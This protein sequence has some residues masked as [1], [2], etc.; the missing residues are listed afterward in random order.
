MKVAST[1]FHKE[2]Q[3]HAI[4]RYNT[5]ARSRNSLTWIP[6]QLTDVCSTMRSSTTFFIFLGLVA[7]VVLFLWFSNMN[8]T[9]DPAMKA[10]ETF[11]NGIKK[12][13][14]AAVQS[15]LDP[16]KTKLIPA[17]SRIVSL[18]FDAVSGSGAFTKRDAR[19]MPFSDFANIDIDRSKGI[20]KDDNG[21]AT[22]SCGQYSL[23]LH[24]VGN[25]WKVFYLD[26]LE[27]K[28]Q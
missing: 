22:V 25:D 7:A 5:V 17:G 13:D 23:Y 8:Q 6:C 20:A 16:A 28:Q 4:L 24:L 27:E 15:V 19:S 1:I 2:V 12:Q 3:N 11:V 10:A 14:A 26:K 18:K 21:L 9:S